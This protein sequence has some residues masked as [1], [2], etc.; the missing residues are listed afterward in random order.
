MLRPT[1]N[2]M[3][4]NNKAKLEQSPNHENPFS[5]NSLIYILRFFRFDCNIICSFKL[6]HFKQTQNKDVTQ[7][8]CMAVKKISKKALVGSE[9]AEIACTCIK[10]G[11]FEPL[12]LPFNRS[13]NQAT[14]GIFFLG[15]CSCFSISKTLPYIRLLDLRYFKQLLLCYWLMLQWIYQHLRKIFHKHAAFPFSSFSFAQKQD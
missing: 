14:R 4:A 3:E 6:F 1:Q 13:Q 15:P 10:I 8:H 9:R 11:N 12:Q 5:N 7:A 2:K